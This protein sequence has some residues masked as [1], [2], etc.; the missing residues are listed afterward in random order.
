ML[1]T[2]AAGRTIRT[3]R[4]STVHYD[5]RG[6]KELFGLGEKYIFDNIKILL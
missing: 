2:D 1:S 4:A 3:Q 6:G 5:I